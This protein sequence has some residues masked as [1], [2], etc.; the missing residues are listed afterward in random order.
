MGQVRRRVKQTN[1][2]EERLIERAKELRDQ[3]ET[4][5]PGI[6][7]EALLKR[8]HQAEAGASMTEW[9]SSPAGM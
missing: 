9:L 7:K 1:S 8:A 4:L 3:A 2:L 5:A 6:E